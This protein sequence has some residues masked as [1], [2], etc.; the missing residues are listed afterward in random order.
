MR[1]LLSHI[2]IFPAVSLLPV[3]V[4]NVIEGKAVQKQ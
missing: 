2:F 3:L 4:V 1:L